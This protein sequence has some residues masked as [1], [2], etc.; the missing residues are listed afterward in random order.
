[1]DEIRARSPSHGLAFF[2][3]S[4]GHQS[5]SLPH[6]V[7]AWP[8]PNSFAKTAAKPKLLIALVILLNHLH[9]SHAAKAGLGLVISSV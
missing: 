8:C 5:P 6:D 3:P 7:L 1:M 2:L 4:A 9:Y